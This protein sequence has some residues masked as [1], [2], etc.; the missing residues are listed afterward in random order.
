MPVYNAMPYLPRAIASILQQTHATFTLLVVDDGSTDGSYEYVAGLGDPRIVL[1]QQNHAGP[2]KAF[3]K[4][5]VY[6]IQNKFLFMV[7]TDADDIS[8]PE[9]IEK[10]IFTLQNNPGIAAISCNCLYM[11]EQ[12]NVFGS[13]TVPVSPALVRWEIQH[14]L[15]GLIQGASAFRTSALAHIGGYNEEFPQAEDT[16]LFMRLS[17]HFVLS[18]LPAFLYRIRVHKNSL[19]NR[20]LPKNILYHLYAIRC[21]KDRIRGRRVKTFQVFI[22]NLSVSEKISYYQEFILL[23]MWKT[24]MENSS[25]SYKFLAALA[26]PKRLLAR[27]MRQSE[28]TWSRGLE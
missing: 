20:N 14:G 19:S 18:N 23:K 8:M 2:S 3:N 11:D 4:A 13:S 9:R 17:E 15:R 21:H 27:V 16:D 10:Q 1:V 24:G 12:E 22:D 5:L 28:L 7:R 6:A 25:L 26:S